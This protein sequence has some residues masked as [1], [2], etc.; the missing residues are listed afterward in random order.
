M[1]KA[2]VLKTRIDALLNV[3]SED[4]LVISQSGTIIFSS[5]SHSTLPWGSDDALG[6]KRLNDIFPDAIADLFQGMVNQALSLNQVIIKEVLFDPDQITYLRDRGMSA[7]CWIEARLAP[8]AGDEP[9]VVCRIED[10][11]RRKKVERERSP[12]Q[13]DLLTGMYNRRALMPVLAQ[14]IAQALRYDWICSLMIIDVDSLRII[15]EQ[16]GWDE[17]DQILKRLAESLNSLKRTADFLARVDEDDFA[18][19]LPET[20]QEQGL[21][22]AERVRNMVADLSAPHSGSDVIFTV[23][24]GV[25]T[26]TGEGDTSEDMY[27]RAESSLKQAQQQGGNRICGEAE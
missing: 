18:I 8:S 25:A 27:G 12:V 1:H 9:S 4:V 26:L 11:S 3:L 15:N 16:Q 20:N 23:S 6:G 19:L 2:N 13:R 5:H 21:L 14:S 22:A 7:P 17:G 24:I 10:I